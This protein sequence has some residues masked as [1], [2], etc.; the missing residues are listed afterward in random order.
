MQTRS[1]TRTH[2]MERGAELG[3]RAKGTFAQCSLTTGAEAKVTQLYGREFPDERQLVSNS[4]VH[5]PATGVFIEAQPFLEG[6][7]SFAGGKADFGN[8]HSIVL[9]A[10][11]L[12]VMRAYA[13]L[14]P[15]V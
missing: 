5:G 15:S 6:W 11:S 1:P 7:P 4:G 14:D 8:G 2:S 10:D 9:V 13:Q 12:A 3:I